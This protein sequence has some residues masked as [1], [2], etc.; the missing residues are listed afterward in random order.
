MYTKINKGNICAADRTVDDVRKED[1]EYFPSASKGRMYFPN[2]RIDCLRVCDRPLIS[3][4]RDV[5]RDLC[6]MPNDNK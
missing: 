5:V 3:N 2:N 6:W 4:V 1:G